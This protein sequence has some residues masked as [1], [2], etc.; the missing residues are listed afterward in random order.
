MRKHAPLILSPRF[1]AIT[2]WGLCAIVMACLCT[3]LAINQLYIG[4]V[5]SDALRS[6]EASALAGGYRL[7][8]DDLLRKQQQSF[9]AEGRLAKSR[10]A[11]L[12]LSSQYHR[13]SLAPMPAADQIVFENDSADSLLPDRVCVSWS[14][15][16]NAQQIPLFMSGLMG[17]SSAMV[18]VEAVVAIDHSP[19]GFVPSGNVSIPAMPF[20]IPDDSSSSNSW[21]HLIEDGHGSDRFSWNA[22]RN[23]IEQGPD[24]LPEMTLAITGGQSAIADGQ[25]IPLRVSDP[26]VGAVGFRQCICSGLDQ[27]ALRY[28]GVEEIQL[29]QHLPLSVIEARDLH[30][31]ADSLGE[32][33]GNSV[34]YFLSES[35][36]SD[37]SNGSGKSVDSGASGVADEDSQSAVAN[38]QTLLLTRPVAARIMRVRQDD[39]GRIDVTLQP[40]VISTSTAKMAQA[41]AANPNRYVYSVRLLR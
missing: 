41:P 14:R 33:R 5:R 1:G 2:G 11:V 40:C 9:E 19:V 35:V 22:D 37:R 10:Q 18:D 24:G 39:S 29:P 21:S 4:M 16:R 12:E 3:G 26:R 38:A 7:L 30:R 23:Q 15:F 34:I 32:M 20:A 6:A 27:K 8:S 31:I 13:T 36:E 28:A 25:L 17:R